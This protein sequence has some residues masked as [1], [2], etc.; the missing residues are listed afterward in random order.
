[1]STSVIDDQNDLQELYY[2]LKKPR[3][4]ANEGP[5]SGTARFATDLLYTTASAVAGWKTGG[6]FTRKNPQLVV[7]MAGSVSFVDLFI[8][9]VA[10]RFRTWEFVKHSP[11]DLLG[12]AHYWSLD[13]KK[14][15]ELEDP[16]RRT[17]ANNYFTI[18]ARL[19][20]QNA[21]PHDWTFTFESISEDS[22]LNLTSGMTTELL[23][24]YMAYQAVIGGTPSIRNIRR[25]W[26]VE[27]NVGPLDLNGEY[28]QAVIRQRMLDAGRPLAQVKKTYKDTYTESMYMHNHY[29]FDAE[30]AAVFDDGNNANH[31]LADAMD[32]AEAAAEAIAAAGGGGN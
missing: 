26:H 20:E 13:E 27:Q 15:S 28:Y 23:S 12:L 21:L 30:A 3:P 31:V 4:W 22:Q 8:R 9:N 1:M 6:A 11:S 29:P 10:D 5:W 14:R 2:K 24:L 32:A 7:A 17:D 16:Q 25:W 19:Q 18:R